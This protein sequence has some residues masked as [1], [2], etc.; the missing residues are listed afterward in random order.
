MPGR[1][2]RIAFH[3]CGPTPMLS[4]VLLRF[5][6]RHWVAGTM[7]I[8]AWGPGGIRV[9]AAG[10]PASFGRDAG[11]PLF[12]AAGIAAPWA[13]P[14]LLG[15]LALVSVGAILLDRK[16][17][18]LAGRLKS[19][20]AQGKGQTSQLEADVQRCREAEA[21]LVASEDRF[22]RAFTASPAVI[23]ITT[24]PE[25][26]YIDINDAFTRAYGFSREEVLGRKSLDIGVWVDAARREELIRLLKAGTRVR[27]FECVQRT[28]DGTIL[29]MECSYELISVGSQP[30]ILCI[31]NDVTERQRNRTALAEKDELLRR[32]IDLVPHSIF[33]KDRR[34][35][36]LF[37]NRWA[38][39]SKGLTTDEMVGLSD[40]DLP[41]PRWEAEAC[42]RDDAEVFA[43]GRPKLVPEETL[44]DRD[45]NRRT[46][47][48]VKIPFQLPG[49]NEPALLGVAMDI[50]EEKAAAA[51]LQASESRL[52]EAQRLTRVG[53]WE[54]NFQT[55]ELVWSDEIFRILELPPDRSGPFYDGYRRLVHPDD[56]AALDA[57]Y[58]G[59]VKSGAPYEVSHRLLFPDGRILWVQERG[60]IEYGPDGR[61][62]RAYG[63]MQDVTERHQ[64]AVTDR[65]LAAIVESSADSIIGLTLEGTVTSWNPA[66][67]RMFGWSASEIVGKSIE[68]IL[69]PDRADEEQIILTRI[70]DGQRVTHFETVRRRKDG[71]PLEVSVAVSPIRD[72][73]G[74]IVGA[75]KTSR[76]ITERRRLETQ[77]RMNQFSVDRAADATFWVAANAEILFV[78]DAACRML[79]YTREEMVGATV[80]DI[81]PNFPPEAWPAHWEELRR[82]R[83]FTFESDHRTKD[84]RT[85]KTEV[86]VNYLEFEGREYNCALMRD[87]TERKR[88][89]EMVRTSEERLRLVTDNARA[90]LVMIDREHRYTYANATYAEI[91]GLP[92]PDI[93]GHRVADVLGPLF[94]EQVRPNLERGLDGERVSYELR[95][96]TSQGS[97]YYAVRYEPKGSGERT[98]FVV[99]VLIEITERKRE[100]RRR[101]MEHAV[102][103]VL[104]EATSLAEATPRLLKALCSA[105]D[106]EFA[107]FWNFDAAA[108]RLRCVETWCEEDERFHALRE[109]TRTLSVSVGQGLPGRVW[110]AGVPITIPE[111]PADPGFLR[112]AEAGRAGLTSAIGFPV[113]AGGAMTGVLVL[114]GREALALDRAQREALSAIGSQ[115][116]QFIARKAA[117]EEL[118]RFV[119]L[120]PSVLYALRITASGP[121]AYWV[122]ENLPIL[123]GHLPAEALT[124]SWWTDGIHPDDRD[125][126]LL[127]GIA[128]EGA[129]RRVIDFRFRRRDGRYVWVR[130]DQRLVTSPGMPAEV[131]GAWSDIT[132]WVTLESQLRQSQK[133]E[134]IGQ[135]S[136]GI[137]HDFNNLLGAVIGNAEL[138]RLDLPPG[139]PAQESV[140]QILAASRRATQLVRQILAF[141]RQ[142]R[143]NLQCVDLLPV[144]E[145]SVRLLRATLPAAVELSLVAEGEL[146]RVRADE[147]QIQQVIINLGTN[148]WHALNERPGRI[149]VMVASLEIG[150]TGLPEASSL[151]PGRH[152]RIRVQDTGCGMDESTVERIFEP[153]FTTK[154]T[155]KGTGLGLSVVHG[156]IQS[157]GG[158]IIVNSA[159]GVGTT[160]DLYLPAAAADEIPAI[161]PELAQL[162]RGN[163]ER[164]LVIDDQP[165]V[166]RAHRLGL[167]RLGYQ[168][169]AFAEAALA[170][171]RFH[172]S[173][174]RFDLVLTDYNMPGLNGLEVARKV[175]AC[176]ART[177]VLLIS[178]FIT[179]D[180]KL[181]AAKAGVRQVV[182]KPAPLGDLG[183][184][185]FRGLHPGGMGVSGNVGPGDI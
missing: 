168:P 57:A 131:I 44:S 28:K 112:V 121:R 37:V 7:L 66:A 67:E 77:L 160:I 159:V 154:E 84:G 164:I 137:A 86:T 60:T 122:S 157:H 132:D 147:T 2:G 69:P 115:V 23:V 10:I 162:V 68:T 110:Q 141:S 172:E 149:L 185:V 79:G 56:V 161:R 100:E 130:D 8:A 43:T 152:L 5:M 97:R 83:T 156:I 182:R 96:A 78:N 173:P 82:R 53:S 178:G 133:M 17:R 136:G 139:H 167:E 63:T 88:I 123:T 31:G 24:Y 22:E 45:G 32:V 134:A 50:T 148:S 158:A 169:E 49:S 20:E 181:T 171:A 153:F 61:P 51:A 73:S 104:A 85:L 55:G 184:A 142:G 101:A 6:H 93:V 90:G 46:F 120:S 145:E 114:F 151:R 179:E 40:L 109:V 98:E 92:S 166:L 33:A 65:L 143:T 76:D 29:T 80:P 124:E 155:G 4:A 52:R 183:E 105:D 27:N 25:G 14:A 41:R 9:S 12:G 36:F 144:V 54:R 94:E 19:L 62:V 39:Q 113:R 16:R 129:D 26:R 75:S 107:E 135:L 58:E 146:P 125:R 128:T 64:A 89:D 119:A 47:R 42:M 87:I 116:G 127:A 21:S 30:C 1:E 117:Q 126:V 140:E 91:L 103:G 165:E 99:V 138:A 102:A 111:I 163:G 71:S 3:F 59:A 150:E 48:T 170:L 72:E 180:L 81:D 174:D 13:V 95:R 175:L 11:V 70:R 18:K 108:D 15:L 118:R 106:W 74:R 177:P 176:R 34:S 35:R 38:A